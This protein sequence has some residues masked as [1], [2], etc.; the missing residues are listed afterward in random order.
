MALYSDINSEFGT[1]VLYWKVN[2]VHLAYGVNKC[3][4]DVTGYFTEESRRNNGKHI[5]RKIYSI[6]SDEFDIYFN[7]E[8]MNTENRNIIQMCYDYLKT[9]E[10][11]L[12]S[13]DI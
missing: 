5:V 6:D 3:Q 9:K 13:L 7:I 8:D 11:F 1:P 4:I 2:T 12:N 10:E